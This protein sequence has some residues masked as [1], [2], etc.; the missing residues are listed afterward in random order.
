MLIVDVESFAV[1]SLEMVSLAVVSV[2]EVSGISTWTALSSI[3]SRFGPSFPP[4]M[5]KVM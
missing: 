1:V 2:T 4:T 3:W 5:E